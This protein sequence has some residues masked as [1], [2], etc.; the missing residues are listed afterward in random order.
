MKFLG[1]TGTILV[2]LAIF[3]QLGVLTR[4]FLDKFFRLGCSNDW[5]PCLDG[6]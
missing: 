1:Q 5:G 2:Y 4:V 3:S 6:A